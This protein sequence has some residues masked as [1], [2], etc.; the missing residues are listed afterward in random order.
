[1]MLSKNFVKE[2]KRIAEQYN[3]DIYK[4][5]EDL[6][7]KIGIGLEHR[8]FNAVIK[9]KKYILLAYNSKDPKFELA[10]E[11]AHILFHGEDGV[12]GFRFDLR[13]SRYEYQANVFAAIFCK[14]KSRAYQKEINNFLCLE[15][16]NSYNADE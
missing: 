8:T 7:I 10:H 6:G 5:I 15:E 2:C 13:M 11:V 3:Y 12:G 14:L 16:L 4:L 1:M 9:D